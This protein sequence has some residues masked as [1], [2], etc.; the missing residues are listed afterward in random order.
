MKRI[1]CA[2]VAILSSL[3]AYASENEPVIGAATVESTE[4][5]EVVRLIV[6]PAPQSIDHKII[7]GEDS[8]RVRLGIANSTRNIKHLDVPPEGT[9]KSVRIV[10]RRGY[11]SV[12]QIFPRRQPLSTCSRTTFM[13]LGDEAIIS[14]AYT[15]WDKER[16]KR[17]LGIIESQKK[18][19]LKEASEQR[20][21][22]L[23]I[24]SNAPSI[25]DSLIDENN[26]SL[27]PTPPKSEEHVKKAS[28][29]FLK[30]KLA[31]KQTGSVAADNKTKKSSANSQ[32]GRNT[33]LESNVFRFSIA[34]IIAAVVAGIAWYLK[35]RKRFGDTPTDNIEIL[36]SRRVGP[37]Q[38]LILAAVQDAKFLLAI[39]DKNVSTLGMIPDE[40]ATRKQEKTNHNN[41]L[42]AIA[43]VNKPDIVPP[44]KEE[45]IQPV[46][47]L[48]KEQSEPAQRFQT[49]FRNAVKAAI[50]GEVSPTGRKD[51]VSNAAGLIAMARMRSNIKRDEDHAPTLEA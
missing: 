51:S 4:A 35:R 28:A 10:P 18:R 45:T 25:P 46:D 37:K 44:D 8:I 6:S 12:I 15:G 34:F 1:I 19:K 9:M 29:P 48:A 13:M 43:A 5:A 22:E 40:H 30:P 50:H 27:K 2:A 49:Q 24:Q 33:H 32:I 17:I 21:K 47:I 38:Q 26:P 42:K 23:L 14:T 36:S 39:S 16:R 31:K 11:N 3:T 7:C 41:L 20:D